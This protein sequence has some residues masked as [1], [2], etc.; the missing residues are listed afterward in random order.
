MY[1]T[2]L[3][4]PGGAVIAVQSSVKESDISE[5]KN[6]GTWGMFES[7]LSK[8]SP[9]PVPQDEEGKDANLKGHPQVSGRL[10][11]A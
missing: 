1:P 9:E 5:K 6:G 2:N 4:D 3:E 11:S 10:L 7:A 8:G